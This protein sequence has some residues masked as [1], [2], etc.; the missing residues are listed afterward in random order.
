M[1]WWYNYKRSAFQ[2]MLV[3]PR[4]VLYMEA[5]TLSSN[6]SLSAMGLGSSLTASS[7]RGFPGHVVTFFLGFLNVSVAV[8]TICHLNRGSY[9]LPSTDFCNKR[10]TVS[11][12]WSEGLSFGFHQPAQPRG[13]LLS[14]FQL[15]CS[16]HPPFS[17]AAETRKSEAG[18]PQVR[19]NEYSSTSPTAT[20]NLGQFYWLVQNLKLSLKM[21]SDHCSRCLSLFN[22]STGNVPFYL[23]ETFHCV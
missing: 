23:K 11:V 5:W 22:S 17:S 20:A 1:R 10:N 9:I 19:L 21:V 12:K 2:G 13:A 16:W 14:S 8:S 18:A 7:F 15:K 6:F 3:N 4:E